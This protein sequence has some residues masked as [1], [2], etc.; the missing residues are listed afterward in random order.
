MAKAWLALLIL[1]LISWSQSPVIV[2]LVTKYVNSSTSSRCFPS[3]MSGS[4]T[5]VFYLRTW[6]FSVLTLR[7][8]V[9]AVLLRCSAFCW[10]FWCLL[11]R[12]PI[13]STLST[14][15]TTV[16]RVHRMPGR[17]PRVTICMNQSTAM[18][19]STGNRMHPCLIPVSTQKGYV[20]WLLCVT[21][22]SRSRPG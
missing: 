8:T 5:L 2:A 12:R 14:S 21:Q 20:T 6:V 17:L 18:E 13:L 16:I 10:A 22:H 9:L 3:I 1:V 15:S 4:C 7:P 19:K 11:D